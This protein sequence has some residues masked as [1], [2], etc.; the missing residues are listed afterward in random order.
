MNVDVFLIK[1]LSLGIYW[2]KSMRFCTFLNMA[3][4]ILRGF[5]CHFQALPPTW[6]PWI[7]PTKKENAEK[8]HESF[9]E[10][11]REASQLLEGLSC[12]LSP[13][14]KWHLR[15]LGRFW[16]SFGGHGLS[17]KTS[18]KDPQNRWFLTGGGGG[19]TW[20]V[21]F[22]CQGD[23]RWE[24]HLEERKQSGGNKSST[25]FLELKKWQLSYF[26]GNLGRSGKECSSESSGL[27]GWD[28]G[29]K[30]AWNPFGWHEMRK[31]L[32]SGSAGVED[33]MR[34]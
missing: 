20:W 32:M 11:G 34:A 3:V 4:S 25:S 15:Y 7:C 19:R 21:P 6:F 12:S 18:S 24:H 28:E 26:L 27:H 17:R 22:R 10:A 8:G 23:G 13:K 29:T 5:E 1:N 14:L 33:S 2:K 30:R 9:I 31:V 16:P